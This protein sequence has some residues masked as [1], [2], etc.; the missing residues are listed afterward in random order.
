MAKKKKKKK[1]V[2]KPKPVETELDLFK[3]STQILEEEKPSG[4]EPK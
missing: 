4:E 1:T 3:Q 2:T